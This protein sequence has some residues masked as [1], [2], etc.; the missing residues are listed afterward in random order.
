MTND[1]LEQQDEYLPR[2]PR[3]RV[4]HKALLMWD[5]PQAETHG[6]AGAKNT[7]IPSAFP[8]KWA[9]QAAGNKPSRASLNR[10]GMYFQGV[11][12]LDQR[13]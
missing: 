6:F 2:T 5:H 7:L 4:R 3:V 10:G 8:L 13:C 1:V 11:A 9:P 12:P